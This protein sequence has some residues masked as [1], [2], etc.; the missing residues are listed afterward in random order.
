M[1]IYFKFE[2]DTMKNEI[3]ATIFLR[4][5]LEH[6]KFLSFPKTHT[7]KLEHMT[8]KSSLASAH[9]FSIISW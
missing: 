8:T 3:P 2:E 4:Q 9:D 6:L 7:S 5:C 1:I